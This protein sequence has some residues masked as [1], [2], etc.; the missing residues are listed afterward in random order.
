M[1]TPGTGLNA[2]T[3]AEPAY[4]LTNTG[5][6]AIRTLNI[7]LHNS[8]IVGTVFDPFGTFG[9][10][11]ALD[12]TPYGSVPVSATWAYGPNPVTEGGYK[13]LAVTFGGAGLAAGQTF[14]FRLD[15]D[16]ASIE[17]PAPGPNE[18][19]GISGFEHIGASVTVGLVDGSS[20]SGEVFTQ[21]S[22][23][24]GMATLASILLA[25]PVLSMSTV[26]GTPLVTDS[27][28][29]ILKANL[30][31]LNDLAGSPGNDVVVDRHR[32][33]RPDRAAGRLRDRRRRHGHPVGQPRRQYGAAE[34]DLRRRH[35]WRGRDGER[36][37]RPA[38]RDADRRPGKRFGLRSL[39]RDG[40]GDR[41]GDRR[42]DQPGLQHPGREG[43]AQ[44]LH[45]RMRRATPSSSNRASPR[46]ISSSSLRRAPI[47]T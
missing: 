26:G 18:S 20:V 32:H 24:G 38:G 15:A 17:G 22:A 19:G 41:S 42:R 14:A 4:E 29:G 45:R 30:P 8:L 10:T 33:G 3:F 36:G 44:Q 5:T 40:G 25:A 35:P 37:S 6:T 46:P 11:T 1:I 23:G 16:P 9:D 21:G 31:G 27:V 34:P 13:T 7:D 43:R 39:R 2:S 28:G 47:T 12:F